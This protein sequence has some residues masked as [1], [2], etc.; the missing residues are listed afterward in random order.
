MTR[1]EA[2]TA[3]VRRVAAAA[4]DHQP[5]LAHVRLLALRRLRSAAPYDAAGLADET[6]GDR[7]FGD[8]HTQLLAA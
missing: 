7:M 8:N 1:A 4:A 3:E 5:H 6:D 2:I